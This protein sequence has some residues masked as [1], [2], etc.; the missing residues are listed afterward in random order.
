M[1]LTHLLPFSATI[2]NVDHFPVRFFRVF[3]YDHIYRSSLMEQI[4]W[5]NQLSTTSVY[6][7]AKTPDNFLF[8]K[9]SHNF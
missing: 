9:L 1:L 4:Q 6:M 2:V 8:F 5:S 7:D 3:V